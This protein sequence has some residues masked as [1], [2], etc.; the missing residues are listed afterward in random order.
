MNEKLKTNFSELDTKSQM[1]ISG[2]INLKGLIM[3]IVDHFR[4]P[5]PIYVK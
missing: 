2:G 1:E 5:F 4:N 3:I